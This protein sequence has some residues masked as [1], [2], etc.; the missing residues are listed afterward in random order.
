MRV[1]NYWFS[2]GPSDVPS[3]AER[4]NARTDRLTRQAVHDRIAVRAYEIYESRR[5]VDGH[6]DEDWRQA[7]AEY[8]AGRVNEMTA[9]R[10]PD[11]H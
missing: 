10:P 2:G 8:A 7:E 4:A 9:I 3:R 6:A 1:K 11:A 5:R